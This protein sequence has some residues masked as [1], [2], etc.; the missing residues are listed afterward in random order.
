LSRI[1]PL[2]PLLANLPSLSRLLL[3]LANFALLVRKPPIPV[4]KRSTKPA[5]ASSRRAEE[6][7]G[8]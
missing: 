6:K 4:D 7:K 1:G 8:Q 5:V 2:M 3:F